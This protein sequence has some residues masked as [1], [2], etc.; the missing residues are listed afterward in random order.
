MFYT[1][2]FAC[3]L[4]LLKSLQKIITFLNKI[5]IVC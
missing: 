4:H 1:D 2:S 3:L 5:D